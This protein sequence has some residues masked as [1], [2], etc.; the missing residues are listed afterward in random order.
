MPGK[1]K[2]TASYS[3]HAGPIIV[4]LL[5]ASAGHMS[6]SRA[7]W[8]L[9]VVTVFALGVGGKLVLGQE[10][11]AVQPVAFTHNVVDA[12]APVPRSIFGTGPALSVGSG[13]STSVGLDNET[14]IAVNPTNTLNTIGGL[15]DY[16]LAINPRER[17]RDDT[18]ACARHV[19]RR[20]YLVGISN[21]VRLRI[22]GDGRSRGRGRCRRPRL[23][24]DTRLPLDWAN[25]RA[26]ARRASGE[27]A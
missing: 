2:E 8:L 18:V 14:S 25:Q 23:L 9:V 22:S 13:E 7:A 6:R 1:R 24:R 17:Q 26:E 15:N 11:D 3:A 5:H 16:Q 27:L 19:R 21:H 4:T 10:D 12:S 20:S